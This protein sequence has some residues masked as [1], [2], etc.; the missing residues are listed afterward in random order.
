MWMAIQP[1]PHPGRSTRSR[2][3]RRIRMVYPYLSRLLCQAF[4]DTVVS[5]PMSARLH[6]EQGQLCGHATCAVPESLMLRK[7]PLLG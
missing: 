4:L 1:S 3:A 2:N 5:Q 7:D 6:K